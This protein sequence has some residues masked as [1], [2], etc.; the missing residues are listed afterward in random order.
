MS[1][2]RHR[3]ALAAVTVALTL[4]AT[5]AAG[6]VAVGSS[7]GTLEGRLAA[8]QAREGALSAGIHHDTQRIEGFQGSIDDLQTR[9]GA[10][11][12]SLAVE[13][14]VL[15]SLRSQLSAAR[16]RLDS[17]QIQL[18][19]DRH[20]LVAQVIAA[21]ETPPPSIVTVIMQAHGFADLIERVGDLQAIS[22]ENASATVHVAAE[23]KTVT[24]EASRLARLEA[25]HAHETSAVLVQRDEVSQLHLALID[26]QLEFVRARDRKSSELG[27]LQ[28]H[29]HS[30][31]HE[32]AKLASSELA[33]RGVAYAYTGPVGEFTSTPQGGDGFFQAPGTDYG[34][35]E[36]PTLVA[37]L[38]ALGIA[39]HLHLIGIS[40][41]RSPAHSVE[42][43][44]F[45]NDPHTRGE[46]SDTPG[47]EG[48]PQATLAR[49]GLIRPFP[50]AAEADH[51]QLLGSKY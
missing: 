41:Y 18:G 11:E 51:I 46:A 38:N 5:V 27:P 14:S 43:G 31:E 32:L 24:V 8:T 15:A 25:S 13:R 44:G 30:L 48:V 33:A 7:P 29:R 4:A 37:H 47:V 9:L 28:G 12:S 21:Y 36:E 40:G 3:P 34:V 26:R 20:V 19:H 10:L 17:L 39:L 6:S 42:V 22:R 45:A 16:T 1:A 50:G 35:G 49:F 23:Q 2:N